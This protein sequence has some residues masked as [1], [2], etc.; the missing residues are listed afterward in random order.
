MV[1]AGTLWAWVLTL[2]KVSWTQLAARAGADSLMVR[3]PFP[4]ADPAGLE[5]AWSGDLVRST[6]TGLPTWKVFWF[7]C[8]QVFEEG[9]KANAFPLLIEM[10][11][12]VWARLSQ[13]G[14]AGAVDDEALATQLLCASILHAGRHGLAEV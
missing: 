7:A 9:V 4:K 6:W 13:E 1:D 3:T 2:E 14:G 5:S 8:R 10:L 12:T 11:Q